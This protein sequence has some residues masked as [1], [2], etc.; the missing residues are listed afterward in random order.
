MEERSGSLG[1]LRRSNRARV[2]RAMSAAG[3]SSRAGIARRT[4]LSRSTVSNIVAELQD[5]GLVVAREANGHAPARSGGRPPNLISL[6][7]TAGL[8][9]G[10][11]LGKRHLAVA[12][13]DLAH[14]VLAEERRSWT[15][16]AMRRAR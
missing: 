1:S 16:A 4:G 2:V 12:V 9:V 5:E 10:I 11:D 15:R 6:D 7:P 13:A 14:N 8:A 3:V